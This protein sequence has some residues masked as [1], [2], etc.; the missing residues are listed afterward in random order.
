MAENLQS[1][2]RMNA[3]ELLKSQHRE[4][5]D[6]FSRFEKAKR[7]EEK[8]KVFEQ[9]AARLVGHDAIE[10]ELFYPACERALGK[11]DSLMEGITEHGLVEFSVFRADKARG[12]DSFEY[13]V[14]VLQE[15]V[16]HHV[17]EEEGDLFPEVQKKLGSQKL[18]ELGDLMLQR[19]EAAM[20]SDFRRPLVANLKQVIMGRAKTT[21]PKRMARAG[22]KR[23]ARATKRTAAARP[24]RRTRRTART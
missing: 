16:E 8:E 15:I 20:E 23:T 11:N 10:R 12:K 19:Y 13:L 9:I 24:K 21:P 3:I 1:Q 2:T 4:V 22:A 5:E 7:M 17:E 6:L 18:A 14:T